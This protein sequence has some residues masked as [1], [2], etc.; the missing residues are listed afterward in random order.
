MAQELST[1]ADRV[2]GTVIRPG[3]P[4]YDEARRVYNGMVD[5]RPAAIVRCHTAV[6]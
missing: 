2:T 5:A 4:G 3:D 1:L 6:A